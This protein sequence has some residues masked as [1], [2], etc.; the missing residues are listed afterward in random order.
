MSGPIEDV[1]AGSAKILARDNAELRDLIERLLEQMDHSY[2]LP[3][4]PTSDRQR[5]CPS[6]KLTTEAEWVMERM[7]GH[8]NRD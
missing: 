2:P 1:L 6:C 4:N 7:V 5:K 3:H 8:A